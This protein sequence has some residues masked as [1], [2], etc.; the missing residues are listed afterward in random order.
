[1]IADVGIGLGAKITPRRDRNLLGDVVVLDAELLVSD[2]RPW[3]KQLYR[4]AKPS[5]DRLIT[6]PLVPYYAWGNRGA[7]EMTVWLN[8]VK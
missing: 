3:T 8:R 7:G 6:A 1:M 2:S 5:L 4:E